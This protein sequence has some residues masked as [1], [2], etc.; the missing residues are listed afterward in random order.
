MIKWKKQLPKCQNL[1]HYLGTLKQPPQPQGMSQR[2][3]TK[4][5]LFDS[6]R[7]T[8]HMQTSLTQIWQEVP[9]LHFKIKFLPQ[10]WPHT[11]LSSPRASII[12]ASNAWLRTHGQWKALYNFFISQ[13]VWT[14]YSPLL[15]PSSTVIHSR[16]WR[17]KYYAPIIKSE[18]EQK[19]AL[20]LK[21]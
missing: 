11:L 20:K 8:N 10:I 15:Y 17:I 6:S 13:T 19:R 3:Q 16:R 12:S 14:L 4:A 18:E 7:P 2:D 21:L 1:K 9:I 5:E